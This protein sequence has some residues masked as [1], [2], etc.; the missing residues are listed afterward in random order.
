M[1]PLLS[2]EKELLLKK[3]LAATENKR[4]E[5]GRVP[6]RRQHGDR[7]PLSF[8]QLQMWVID[9]MT[10]GN[11]A[12]NLPVGYRL[13]GALNASALERSFN[14]VI[15]RHE[16]LRTTFTVEND[17]PVQRIHS[18][19]RIQINLVELDPATAEASVQTLAAEEALKS[20]DIACLPLIRVSVFRLNESEHV[21]IINLHHIVVDGISIELILNEVDA[22]YRAFTNGQDPHLPTPKIQYADFALW[23]R[24][25]VES[26]TYDDQLRF[27]QNQLAGELPVLELPADFPRPHL[28]SFKGSNAFL[29]LPDALVQKLNALATGEG[30]TFFMA[31]LAAFQVLLCRYSGANEIVIGTPIA[32]RNTAEF[33]TLIGNCL[34][35][36]ALRCDLSGDPDFVELLRR[37]RD[38]ALNAFSNADLPFEQLMNHLK[39]D[40]NPNRN[41]V[42]QVMLQ[43]LSSSAPTIG[44]LEI[45]NFHFDL[46]LAQFD[47]AI[48]FYAESGSQLV[49]FEYCTDV[50]RSETI[51][52]LSSS[53]LQLLQSVVANSHQKISKMPILS[54]FERHEMLASWNDTYRDYPLDQCVHSLFERAAKRTPNR[55]AVECGDESLTYRQLNEKAN[56]LANYLRESGVRPESCVGIFLERSL[57]LIV[58]LIGILKAG[59][60]YVPMDPAFPP[61]RLAWIMEDAD[62]SLLVTHSRLL[63]DLPRSGVKTVCLD[64]DWEAIEHTAKDDPRVV[65]S[66][67]SLAYVIYT[68]GSTGKPK[69]VMV[70]HRSVVNFLL[71]MQEEPGF[72]QNDVL[73]AVT[74]ICFD[75]AGLE[76]FLPLVSGAKLVVAQRSEVIDGS[77]L[78]ERISN[79]AATV[80]QATPATWKLLLE[81]GWEKSPKLKML[82]GGEALPRELANRMLPRGAQLW[83]MYGPTETTIWSSLERVRP[84]TDGILIGRP[85]ANTKFYIVDKNLEPVPRGVAGE[86]LIAGDGLARGYRNR[87][88]LTAERFVETSFLAPGVRAYKTGDV[89]RFRSD[90]RVEL[91][92]RLDHQVKVRGYRIELGEIEEVLSQHEAVNDAVVMTH[93]DQDGNKHLVAYCI[94]VAR[95][96]LQP[97]DLARFLQSKLP[98]YM[99]PSCFVEMEEFPLTPNSKIDREAFPKPKQFGFEANVHFAEPQG[100]LEQHL[101]EIWQ[102]ALRKPAIGANDNFFDLG[103]HSLLAAQ[104]F[105]QMD[106]HLGVKLPLALLFQA[107]TIRQLAACIRQ[108]SPKHIWKSLVPIQTRGNNPPIFLVH[109]AEGDVLLYKNLARSLGDNQPVY[110]L[111]FRGLNGNGRAEITV[112]EMATWY[113]E[114]IQ[115]LQPKGPYFLGGYCLGGTIA[116]EIAQQLR[117]GGESVALLA[118]FETYNIAGHSKISFPLR[119]IHTA[120]NLYFHLTNLLLSLSNGGFG[121]FSEKLAVELG[122]AKVTLNILWSEVQKKLRYKGG[123]Q[124]HHRQTRIINDHAYAV[125]HPLPYDGKITLFRTKTHYRG[126][127]SKDFGWGH[128]ARQGVDVVEMPFYPRGTLNDPF[129]EDIAERLKVEIDKI[130]SAVRI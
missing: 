95:G 113:K 107:P 83:N 38:T 19:Y 90:G 73:V 6:A 15:R 36:V 118:M 31:I 101:A 98:E 30:C 39:I 53:F 45:S 25:T 48:H 67:S 121:F 129:V 108:K 52:R 2:P 43:V 28:Q 62:V 55:V 41:P 58:G 72:D 27:W 103:G 86:L 93:E 112:E 110:G 94:P 126:F 5:E 56:R 87:P 16:I 91:L 75:I 61:E 124:Y 33:R 23:Q 47:L 65:L 21:L 125:Y 64:A 117:R 80:L 88:D 119:T 111:Q 14:E 10:L 34:N 57:D 84:G 50:F 49:R 79:S 37:S 63:Q 116:L 60:A 89:A 106:R 42:F 81:A 77:A 115:S 12:Y 54:E 26:A 105:A 74:T 97:T 29:Q 18:E 71:S 78:L 120:Q 68:S 1:R 44:E 40:R 20:F 70:E 76:I 123:L 128:I 13:R 7:V 51:E 35:M 59:A 127:N 69:G 24:Q 66:P 102:K 100:E 122:R 46:K 82:C 114:E 92:G 4:N 96:R 3:R 109:G 8:S 22:F 11:P 130:L 104:V 17:E 32:L 85:I 9:R 99:I